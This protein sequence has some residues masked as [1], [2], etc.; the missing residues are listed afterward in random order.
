MKIT[1]HQPNFLPYP[2]FFTK[3]YH[4]D[5]LVIGDH[6]QYS[7]KSFINRNKIKTQHGEKWLTVPIIHNL[8]QPIN[9]VLINNNPINNRRWNYIHL[10][11]LRIN[12]SKANY[13]H[14]YIDIFK[15][16]YTRQWDYLVELNIEFIKKILEILDIK[17]DIKLTSQLNISGE[18][19]DQII[20]ICKELNADTYI[21]GI[22]GKNY[23][24][25]EEFKRNSIKLLYNK[26]DCPVYNQQFNT[27]GFIPNLSI[28]DMLF[29]VGEKTLNLLI[30]NNKLISALD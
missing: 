8:P 14:T 19:T 28:I 13:Y 25:E 30:E 20:N 21:S 6:V 24:N 26:F 12:Y 2:G 10:E 5:L 1:I 7:N 11:T 27:L 15:D 18:K 4:A 16:V 29:N 17:I 9:K 3:V 23:L 22:G